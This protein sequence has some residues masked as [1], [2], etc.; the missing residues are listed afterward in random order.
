M[1][2]AMVVNLSAETG[3]DSA[4]KFARWQHPAME[5]G[6]RCDVPDGTCVKWFC[7]YFEQRGL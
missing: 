6:A 3:G 5:R 4:I 7:V 2:V 1:V